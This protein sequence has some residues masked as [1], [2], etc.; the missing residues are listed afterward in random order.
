[1]E[2]VVRIQAIVISRIKQKN[3]VVGLMMKRL[4]LNGS[5]SKVRRLQSEQVY[6]KFMLGIRASK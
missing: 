2:S 6:K 4:T 1:M 3:C 5:Y